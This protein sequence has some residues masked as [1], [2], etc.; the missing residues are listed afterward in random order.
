VKKLAR[1]SALS[2]KAKENKILVVEDFQ[3]DAPKTRRVAELLEKLG[4]N[5]RKVLILTGEYDVNLY[6]SA[7]NIPYKSVLKAPQF[8]T[9]DV[10]NANALI[11]QNGAVNILNEVLAK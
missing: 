5:D 9:Y 6:K 2:Y 4:V 3:F 1:R 7:R 8:S 10:L 11:I